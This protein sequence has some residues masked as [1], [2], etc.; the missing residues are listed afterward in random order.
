MRDN[1]QLEARAKALFLEAVDRIP[2]MCDCEDGVHDAHCATNKA[3]VDAY[4]DAWR[5]AERE[6]EGVDDGL[7]EWT[8]W[9]GYSH[10]A[11]RMG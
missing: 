7:L 4:A 1:P 6:Q 9:D 5:Q 2:E 10:P 11:K 3:H 8:D